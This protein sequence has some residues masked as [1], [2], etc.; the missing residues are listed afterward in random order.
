MNVERR[1]QQLEGKGLLP[2]LYSVFSACRVVRGAVRRAGP[3]E[4]QAWVP[5]LPLRV[6]LSR[7]GGAP[8]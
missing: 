4:R 2:N 3:V 1:E 5:I 7:P 6:S 8:L